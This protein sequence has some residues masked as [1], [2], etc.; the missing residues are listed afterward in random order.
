[1]NYARS[2]THY[3]LYIYDRMHNELVE[4]STQSNL[5]LATLNNSRLLCRRVYT[6]DMFQPTLGSVEQKC[7]AFNPKQSAVLKS[8]F[9]WRDFTARQEDESIRYV[10]PNHMLIKIAELLPR[11]TV[12]LFS[13]CNPHP[14]PLLKSN[15]HDVI[16]I[17]QD[18][19][20]DKPIVFEY[21]KL[22]QPISLP[23]LHQKPTS[24]PEPQQSK[25]PQSSA[26]VS[27]PA[28]TPVPVSQPL[29]TPVAASIPDPAS[30]TL[31]QAE[32]FE[33][34]EWL[35]PSGQRSAT[36]DPTNEG[37]ANTAQTSVSARFFSSPRASKPSGTLA[38]LSS[39]IEASLQSSLSMMVPQSMEEIFQF[40]N[41][42]RKRNKEKKRLKEDSIN[43]GPVSPI[44]F[45]DG[46]EEDPKSKS[47][48]PEDFMREIGW[49]GTDGAKPLVNS[50]AP[51]ANKPAAS[52]EVPANVTPYDYSKHKSS[53]YGLQKETEKKPKKQQEQM[54][55]SVPHFGKTSSRVRSS[56]SNQRTHTASSRGRR[57]Q[58]SSR[59]N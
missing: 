35:K 32:L 14:S 59:R 43:A 45:G 33:K 26:A 23:F 52:K 31:T 4:R 16:K 54:E 47:E 1:M 17:I 22:S 18:A 36:L 40:S 8:L 27:V 29:P 41:A 6:K 30:S 7:P 11:E 21:N 15:A 39:E 25:A 38:A 37:Q 34:A 58:K 53:N 46:A 24:T 44:K 49:L 19:Q 55:V 2:D 48:K 56:K 57:G 28:P 42:N 10:L 50:N 13:C 12:E 20:Q 51:S 5:L 3:L 9:E